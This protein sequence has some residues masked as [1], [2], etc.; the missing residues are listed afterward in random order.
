[1][2][3][4]SSIGDQVAMLLHS[5][6]SRS[7]SLSCAGLVEDIQVSAG[8]VQS[9]CYVAAFLFCNNLFRMLCFKSVF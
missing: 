4:F 8:T 9:A 1:M 7:L 6:C 3:C 2:R 5:V